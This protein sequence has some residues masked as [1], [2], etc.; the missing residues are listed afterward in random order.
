VNLPAPDRIVHD[1]LPKLR[2]GAVRYFPI[3]HHSPA[4]ATHA[5]RWIA[6]HRPASV[7]IEGGSAYDPLIPALLD[8]RLVCPVA[9]F[10]SVIDKRGRIENEGLPKHFGP[11]RFAAF[12]PLCDYSPELAALHA[13]NEIGARLRF[14]DLDFAESTFVRRRTVKPEDPAGIRIE[15]LAADSHL[16]HSR[17]LQMVAAKFGCRDFNELWD[18]LFEGCVDSL[19]T[20]VFLDR[21]ATYCILARSEYTPEE[22]DRDA[23][24][25]REAFMAAAIVDEIK[26]NA[27]EKRA[28]P[29][30]V[31]TGGFHS[32]VL[33][34]LVAA[35]TAAPKSHGFVDGEVNQYLIR[36]SF[37]QLDA[38]AGYSAGMPSPAFYDR[39]WHAE[40]SAAARSHVVAEILIEIARQ[41]RSQQIAAAL[42][43]ADALAA[44]QLTRQLAEFR[45]HPW[46]LR[47]DLLDGVRS[48]FVKGEM[49][50][51]GRLLLKIVYEMLAGN[52]IGQTPPGIAIPPIV[53]D[54]RQEAKRLRL[55]VDAVER[56]EMVL[57]L[58]RSAPHR[59]V[60][61]LFHRLD[62]LNAPFASFQAGP[63]FVRG[64]GLER[65]QEQWLVC[66]S[67]SIES[68]LI[69]ASVYGPT[70]EDAALH[71]LVELVGKL[72]EEGKGRNAA[73]AVELLVRSCRLGLH[74][75]TDFLVSLVASHVAEDPS[76]ASLVAGLTQLDLLQQAREPLEA[77]HLPQLP[78]VAQSAYRRACKLMDDL[79]GC[80]DDQVDANLKALQTLREVL[81]GKPIEDAE[82]AWDAALFHD[83][84]VRVMAYPLQQAQPALI[85]A[86]AGIRY[87]NGALTEEA[88][89]ALLEGYLRADVKKCC[90]LFRGLLTTA[91]EIAWQLA[92]F[93]KVFQQQLETWDQQ[94]FLSA[95]PELRLAF[96]DFTPREIIQV[97]DQVT[98]LHDGKSLGQLVFGDIQESDVALALH[99][100]EIVQQSL[101]ADGLPNWEGTA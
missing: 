34:D 67:P 22:L 47:E 84:L 35:R 41:T 93:V 48:C 87:S 19:S 94:T 65:L 95:L 30:L 100:T 23:T 36:Y 86:A 13:G 54:F 26:R 82:H 81:A 57:D 5:R 66:W 21:L 38:L 72:D 62:F 29:I 80:P 70:I 24:N 59:Q 44:V 16:A 83:A 76:F 40:P 31:V 58:Y 96:A 64:V 101:Q 79:A 14:I 63:D 50:T 97:A 17:Y 71:K 73:A 28:G 61:R 60:S 52:R 98:H 2:G 11:A 3:R 45:G 75:R 46:P 15:S 92:G 9:I 43:T 27:E 6:E 10:T 33:P 51:E 20:D 99:L 4:C 32:V 18:H 49:D 88:L 89:L 37:D 91:R 90:A 25:A 12:F 1:W 77:T 69:E 55:P 74:G 68:A 42:S 39:L 56:R 8:D 85:G 7:L 53:E 78:E